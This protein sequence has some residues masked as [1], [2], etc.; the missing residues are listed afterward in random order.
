MA[1]IAAL[2]AHGTIP[3]GPCSAGPGRWAGR[4]SD[5]SPEPIEGVAV[6]ADVVLVALTIAVFA[7]LVLVVQAVVRL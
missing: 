5:V 3:R 6:M 1:E 7:A 4:G 2:R